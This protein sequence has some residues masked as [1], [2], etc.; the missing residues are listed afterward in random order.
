MLNADNIFKSPVAKILV[1]SEIFLLTGQKTAADGL[2][3]R[4]CVA[5]FQ[6][7]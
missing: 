5:I 7:T 3:S 6:L 1:P 2:K 4:I